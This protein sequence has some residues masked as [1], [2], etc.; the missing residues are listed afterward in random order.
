MENLQGKT[1]FITG[2][3]S[4]IGLGI[5]QA[6]AQR[7]MN[8]VIVDM[9]QSAIDEAL[10]YFAEN[11]YKAIGIKLNVTDREAYAKAVEEAIAAFGNIHL[12]V[13]N[14][15]IGA[16]H[17]PL[18]AVTTKDTDL[19]IDINLTSVLN[20]IQ[21][22]VPHMLAHGEGG[23][24]VSTA[25]KAALIPV[26]NCGLYNLTKRAVVA[27]TETLASDLTGTTVGASVFC[28][29]PFASNLS[30]SSREVESVIL[31]EA[32]PEPAPRATPPSGDAPDFD[33]VTRPAIEAGERVLRGVERGDLYILT[34]KEFQAGFEARI[35]AILRAFP[36]EEIN[37]QFLATFPFLTYNPVFEKQENVPAL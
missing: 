29:G 36:D 10:P 16:A 15:G 9:R 33:T 13:N 25:S 22:I 27:L 26:P 7:G 4:G 11:G 21:A 17:E 28:P 34:H 6:S 30:A 24:I 20:G 14:A 3:A 5:A 32:V 2:G 23:H 35:N 8:V 19:A 18:W 1:A 31:G 12:L 37:P